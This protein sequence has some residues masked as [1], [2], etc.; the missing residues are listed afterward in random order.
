MA[1]ESNIEKVWAKARVCKGLPPDMFRLDACGALIMRDKYGKVNPYG[2]EI[3][4]VFPLSLGGDDH[5]DNLRALHYEN[6]RSKE[7]DYPSYTAVV[8]Y[9]G[10]KAN[11]RNERN[12]TVN[13]LLRAK[14]KKLYDNA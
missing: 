1:T 9:D 12:L 4:H 6:N 13:K 14:L 11:V 2:W 3:D 7:N 10:S 8:K 5:F